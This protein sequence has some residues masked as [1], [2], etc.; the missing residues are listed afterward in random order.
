MKRA[1]DIGPVDAA[2]TRTRGG[3]ARLRLIFTVAQLESMLKA[4]LEAD[5]ETAE[6]YID[7][8]TQRDG[9]VTQCDA[10]EEMKRRTESHG[11][12]DARASS[13]FVIEG[14]RAWRAWTSAM[15][16]E[17][18]I[19]WTLTTTHVVDGKSR[20]GWWFP[21]LFPPSATGPPSELTD[22]EAAEFTKRD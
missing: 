17:R 21:A 2:V 8:V 12:D 19:R 18:A 6:A 1:G 15:T 9:G 7:N 20:R 4:A 11:G 22:E 5:D 10:P 13:V 16:R 14:T 3:K